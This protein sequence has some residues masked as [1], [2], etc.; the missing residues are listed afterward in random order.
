MFYH[1]MMLHTA[2]KQEKMLAFEFNVEMHTDVDFAFSF[3]VN[4]LRMNP[5]SCDLD[6]FP[7]FSI[8]IC[9]KNILS[10]NNVSR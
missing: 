10:V 2:M 9:F 1:P 7:F 6:L 3:C 5:T 8:S 4:A